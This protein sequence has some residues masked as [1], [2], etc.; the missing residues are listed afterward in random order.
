MFSTESFPAGVSQ[1]EWP[2]GH[3]GR[4]SFQWFHAFRIRF[5]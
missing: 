3:M 2:H 1:C 5:V 4:N